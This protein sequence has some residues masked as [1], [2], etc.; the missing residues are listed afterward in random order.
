[1]SVLF[2][3]AFSCKIELTSGLKIS[4]FPPK[5]NL[6]NAGKKQRFFCI[7]GYDIE[8]SEEIECLEAG[9]WNAPP[10]TCSKKCEL[11]EV[12]ENLRFTPSGDY[13]FSKGETLTFECREPGF[14]TEGK[15]NIECLGQGEWSAPPPICKK[16]CKVP[17]LT[18]NVLI[19]PPVSD[20]AVSTG[21]T[22]TFACRHD[23]LFINGNSNIE[24]SETGEW[25][26]LPPTCAG[27][28]G[29]KTPPPLEDGDTVVIIKQEY[30]HNEKVQYVCQQS[31]VM[32]G[33]PYKICKNGAW[34][35]DIRCLKSCTVNTA[36]MN[37]RNIEF[38]YSDKNKLYAPHNGHLTF[39]CKR[40]TRKVGSEPM[41]RKCT[42]GQMNLPT[43]Q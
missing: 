2:F 36:E 19:H 9:E 4:G 23:W 40:G 41:R 8:G 6:V 27:P 34:T 25:S 43:C 24:C 10:P 13:Y 7:D 17:T 18:E 38:A 15:N 33:G 12:P 29:C 32:E 39:S 26:G 30:E 21:Q 1:M 42:N 14:F 35:G 37:T 31:Y 20:I 22:I 28:P 3:S 5:D 11:P 16:K